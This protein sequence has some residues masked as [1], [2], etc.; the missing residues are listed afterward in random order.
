V[1]KSNIKIIPDVYNNT[2]LKE[3]EKATLSIRV[4]RLNKK[5]GIDLANIIEGKR[6][7]RYT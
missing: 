1:K 2:N 5:D 4:E 7:R 3:L 6:E